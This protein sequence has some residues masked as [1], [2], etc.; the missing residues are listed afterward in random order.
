MKPEVPRLHVITHVDSETRYSHTDIGTLCTEA[1]ADC[2]QF[3]E[4]RRMPISELIETAQ[5]LFSICS[6]NGAVLVINDYVDVALEVRAPGVHVGQEDESVAS[7][8]DRLGP[9]GLIGVTANTLEEAMLMDQTDADYLG[10]GPVFGTSTK[11]SAAKT[12]GVDGLERIVSSV[13]KPVI[14][15]GNIDITNVAGVMQAGASG[16]A[17]ISSVIRA[18]KPAYATSELWEAVNR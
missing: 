12:L 4:K 18:V 16:I 2:I 9:T 10:V 11:Q 1:G 3:R 13:K 7:V 6:S 14:A 15:I 8:R 17:V 5:T